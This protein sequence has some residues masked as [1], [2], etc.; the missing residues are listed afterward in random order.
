[1]ALS[2]TFRNS[3]TANTGAS[4]ASSLT[5]SI[6]S[7]TVANDIV[8][9]ALS[10]DG[11]SGA[12]ITSPAGW[13]IRS[14]VNQG[15]LVKILVCSR[16][17][18]GSEAASYTWTFD[19]SRM[20][21]GTMVA[22]SGAYLY[23]SSNAGT[24]GSSV[25][26]TTLTPSS[27]SS[28]WTGKVVNFF[29]TRNTTGVNDLTPGGSYVERADTC[30][31]ATPFIG[32]EAQE[33]NVSAFPVAGNTSS[34]AT[35]SQSSTFEA[36]SVFIQDRHGA[37]L[38]LAPGLPVVDELG[39]ASRT[40]LGGNV[41]PPGWSTH[42]PNTLCLLLVQICDTATTV[43]T[44]TNTSGLTWNF[45][46]RSNTQTGS[47]EAW[48]AWAKTPIFNQTVTANFASNATTANAALIPIINADAS[49][50]D[51]SSAIGASNTANSG[52]SAN[53]SVSL[54]TTRANSM[55]LG[56]YNNPSTAASG[57]ALTGTTNF[58]TLVSNNTGAANQ[59]INAPQASGTTATI[60]TSGTL[61]AWNALA[62]EVLGGTATRTA[63]GT[64]TLAGTR[65]AA[66]TRISVN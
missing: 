60:G 19:S 36:V 47:V 3:S 23:M 9:A 46:T 8:Y 4:T 41:A 33:L 55:I 11:G 51:G 53:V 1:M 5:I 40:T 24:A 62:V 38:R 58:R 54:T 6:P 49:S 13:S 30:T 2:A 64:R 10:V 45:I 16:V 20:A 37:H 29:A 42:Y 22:Y 35:A 14:S 7:G 31:T 17:I 18:D 63:A 57:T 59:W 61:P 27:V 56:C 66:G 43:S 25:G 44:V 15:T 65:T 32:I 21:A 12:T 48:Y 52:V 34:A 26:S 50:G 28:A 39:I